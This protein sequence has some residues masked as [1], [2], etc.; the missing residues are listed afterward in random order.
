MPATQG[1]G[2]SYFGPPSLE[3]DRGDSIPLENGESQF[4]RLMEDGVSEIPRKASR[5]SKF[6]QLFELHPFHVLI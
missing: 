1:V 6:Q 3:K 2:L 5:V 4:L